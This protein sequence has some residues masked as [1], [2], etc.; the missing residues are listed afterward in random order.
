MQEET[1]SNAK[2]R[3]MEKQVPKEH[4]KRAYQEKWDVEM[5]SIS[6]RCFWT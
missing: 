5:H 4:T 2:H 6:Q 1:E 3:R